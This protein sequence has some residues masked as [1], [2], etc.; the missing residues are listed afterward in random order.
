MKRLES[1]IY[2]SYMNIEGL[3]DFL[4]KIKPFS[5]ADKAA[6]RELWVPIREILLNIQRATIQSGTR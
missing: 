1:E 3:S 5:P 4:P 6:T 2:F